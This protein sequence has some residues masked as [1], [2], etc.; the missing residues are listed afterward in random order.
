[1]EQI[2]L[3]QLKA[4]N[5]VFVRL[6]NLRRWTDFTTQSKYNELAKQ[7]FNCIVAYM[8]AKT[9]EHEGKKICYENFPKIALGRAFA[10]VHVYFDTPEHK[11]HEICDLSGKNKAELDRVAKEI[12]KEE[13]DE[14]FAD[15]LDVD[16]NTYETRIYKAATKIATYIELLEQQ[17][18][19]EHL[20][21]LQEIFIDL[22]KYMDI[23]GVKEFINHE[24]EIFK[25][26]QKIST[27]RNQ[28][29]WAVHCYTMECSVLGHL[30]DTAVWAYLIAL[31]N[32]EDTEETATKKFFI[33]IFHD[34]AEVWTKDIP[35]P[36]KNRIPGFRE[37][38]EKFELEMLDRHMYS[39]VPEYLKE[40]LKSVMMEDDA[41]K[42]LKDEMKDAD[43]LS[44]DS[45]CYRSLLCGSRDTYFRDAVVNH[46]PR[47]K[48]KL[49][50]EIHEY[51][52]E[53]V[54]N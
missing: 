19:S 2:T 28:N 20:S 53:Y 54:T 8:L 48:N 50:N 30:F 7:A 32:A 3:R 26:L 43:Y 42:C 10:K 51:F 6:N 40:A 24:S 49:Y 12:I 31:S 22:N 1:M 21:K 39:V 11:I 23:P 46:K 38:T 13:T 16:P 41:N 34:I 25:L 18:N 14:W 9:C 37:A 17:H 15:F 35:S 5:K 47:T 27:L 52:V 45:E 44:A 36:I 33:G 4:T 29:R